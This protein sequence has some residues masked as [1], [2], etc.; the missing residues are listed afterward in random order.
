[1]RPDRYSQLYQHWDNAGRTEWLDWRSPG[2]L[3]G[4]Q[5][6]RDALNHP[7]LRARSEADILH[8]LD[9]LRAECAERDRLGQPDPWRWYRQAWSPRVLSAACDIPNAD[10]ARQRVSKGAREEPMIWLDEANAEIAAQERA[11]GRS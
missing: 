1:M 7:E 4:R 11:N 2:E 10:I 3:A 6:I 8:G 5:R 9:M